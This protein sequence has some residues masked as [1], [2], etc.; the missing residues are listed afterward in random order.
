MAMTERSPSVEEIAH[1]VECSMELAG[2][3]RQAVSDDQTSTPPAKLPG[4]NTQ[5]WSASVFAAVLVRGL[6]ACQVL[7]QWGAYGWSFS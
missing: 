5:S 4:F 7:R 1:V 6:S 3:L 2:V